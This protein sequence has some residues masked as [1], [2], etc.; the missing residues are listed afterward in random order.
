MWAPAYAVADELA[1][2]LGV[3]NEDTEQ[4]TLAIDAASRAIDRACGRQFGSTDSQTRYYTP[5]W[6][7]DRWTVSV[8]DICTEP[9]VEVDGTVVD[10]TLLPRNA[11]ANGRPWTRIEY[12]GPRGEVAVT[13]EFGWATVPYPIMYATLVQASRFY[14]RRENIAGALNR[15]RVDDVEYGWAAAGNQELDADVLASVSPYR[16]LWTAM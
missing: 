4:L 13:A 3:P 16:R 2:W 7:R 6:H 11:P 15:H 14:D 10:V 9:V 8:D 5:E 12:T 1:S